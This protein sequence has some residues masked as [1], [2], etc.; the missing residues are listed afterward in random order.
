MTE[1]IPLES[2]VTTKNPERT[3]EVERQWQLMR[4]CDAG[5]GIVHAR[6]QIYLPSPGGFVSQWENGGQQMYAAYL[7]RAQLPSIISPAINS[8]VGI[9]HKAEWRIEMPPSMQYLWEGATECG[10]SL[11][12]FTRRITREL[13]LMGRFEI[14]VDAPQD[15]GNPYLVGS[16]AESLINWDKDFFV[17][18]ESGMVR[19]GYEWKEVVQYRVHRLDELGRYEQVLVDDNGDQIGEPYYPETARDNLDYVPIVILGA[20]DV[21]QDI[22]DPPLLGAARAAIAIYRLDADYRHQLYMSGQETL[23]VDNGD[24]PEAIGPAVCLTITSTSEQPASVYYVS[25]TCAGIEAH[26]VAIE[27]GWEDAAKAGAKLFD[28]GAAIESGDARRMRQN[29]ESAT[30]QTIANS[31]A[32]GLEQSLKNIAFMLGLNPDD[33]T[34]VPPR[35]LLDSPM[36]AAEVVQLVAAWKNDGFSYQTLY[37]NLQRGQ[38][39]SDERD[40]DQELSMMNLDFND[41]GE[42]L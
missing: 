13:L 34:V 6:G 4:D 7:S 11:E 2:G 17:F 8:M 25:P 15:G 42:S 28:T 39:A 23:V 16:K 30:L 29:A 9:V 3:A 31:A 10:M 22:E 32:E 38:I 36:T 12:A 14:G 35:N 41:E 24:A 5:D 40:A 20:R 37:E 1:N 21:S 26:R 27:G 19:D 18:N 33:V